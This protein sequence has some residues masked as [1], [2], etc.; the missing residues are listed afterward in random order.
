MK[1]SFRKV[2][3]VVF[4]LLLV[5]STAA[6]LPDS[7]RSQRDGVVDP[8]AAVPSSGGAFDWEMS[9]GETIHVMLNQHPY[10]EAIIE[11][12]PEFEKKTGIRVRYSVTPESNY[13]DKLTVSLNARNGR[14]DVFMTGS[15]Q[16][17]EFLFSGYVQELDPF[18]RDKGKTSPDY[19]PEDF[20]E[21]V[22]NG[23][24]WNMKVGQPVGTGPLWAVPLGFEVNVLMYNRRAL[25]KVGADPP[26]TFDELIETASKLN[27]WN[28]E[29]S[30]GIAV[31]GT[32]SWA[33]IH[34]GYMTAYSMAGAKDF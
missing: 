30:Y 21:G 4:S 33:T 14:P 6:C 26:K 27:G 20:F 24:R 5:G 7:Q 23:N 10:A 25:D 19:D 1:G 32:R 2:L 22:L 15:Y 16:L 13:F 3:L 31:R 8:G 9:K 12:L 29:G 17:W 11:R 34:P 18:I 28:G